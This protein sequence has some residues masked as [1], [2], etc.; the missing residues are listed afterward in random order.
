MTLPRYVLIAGHGRSG[1]NWLLNLMDLSTETHCRNEPNEIQG[2]ALSGLPGAQFA[3]VGGDVLATSWDHAIE[4][5]SEKIGER[6]PRPLSPKRHIRPIS[7][8]L[9]LDALMYRPRMR[10]FA[11]WAH[12]LTESG[13]W[14]VP[15]WLGNRR[16]LTNPL[17]VVKLVQTPG[18]ITW[19]L[20]NRPDVLVLH[21]VRHPGGFLN[22]WHHRY[23]AYAGIEAVTQDNAARIRSLI[24]LD[25]NWRSEIPDID[26]MS[27]EESELWYWK[28]STETI[29]NAGKN[30]KNCQLII[31]E[32]MTKDP[33]KY[34]EE[35]Y[36]RCGLL[37]TEDVNAAIIASSQTS[38]DIASAWT[39]RLDANQISLAEKFVQSSLLKDFW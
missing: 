2:T 23:V 26:N 16:L 17:T 36:Q 12:I 13:E 14:D 10:S 11:K 19:V 5:T 30:L 28:Y 21:I 25:K 38:V 24:K 15:F 27:V 1:T 20:K 8:A 4:Q 29:Y 18:W 9:G 32:N 22:S 34:A 7:R 37:W 39:N 35:I 6:D 3:G 31:Y 33:K